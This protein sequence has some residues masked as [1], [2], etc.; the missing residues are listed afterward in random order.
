MTTLKK[1][2][3]TLTDIMKEQE[4]YIKYQETL[5]KIQED[6]ELYDKLNE[7]RKKNVELHYQRRTLKDEANLERQYHDFMEEKLIHE[8]LHWEQQTL[9]ML[10]MIYKEISDTLILD[11]DFL[12]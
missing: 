10:R 5:K 3:N 11:Y 1:E 7:Y 12:S 9:S 4:C 6:S 8:F 2:L